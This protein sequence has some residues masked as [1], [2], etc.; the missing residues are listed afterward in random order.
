MIRIAYETQRLSLRFFLLMLVLF[1]VQTF[2]GLLIAA[3]HIDPT[4]LSGTL[5]FNVARTEHTNLGIFW[6]LSGFIATI[7]FVGP[8]LSKRELAAPWLIKFLFYALLA[9][10]IWNIITQSLAQKGIAGWWMGQPMLQEGL[11]YLEAGRIADIVILIGFSILCYIVL[12]TFPP[13]SSWNEIHWGLGLGVLA[14][15]AVWIFGM[16]FVERLDLQEY[17]RWY[18]VHYWVEGVWEVI[19]ISLVGFLLILMFKADVKAVG[20]AVFWGISLVWLSGLLGNAHHYFWIGT[21]EFWQFWGSLFSALEPLPLIFCFWHI[22]LDAHQ[23]E[24]P[25]ANL[26][27]FAFLLGS[28]VLEQV[29][30]GI[31]GFTMTFALTNVWSHGTW[32]T[33]SH[34]HL[35]LFGTFGML[36][37]SAAYYAVP[38]MRGVEHFDQRAGKLAFWLV[39]T[40]MLGLGFA[41]A[42]GGS[43]Q[44]FVYRTLGL[45]WFA[46]DVA[47][48]MQFAKILVPIFG[49]VFTVGVCLLVFDLLTLGYR[50]PVVSNKPVQTAAAMA[51]AVPT[52]WSRWLTGWEAG[53]WLLGMW[54][55]GGIITLGL[56]SFNLETVRQGNA[57]LPYLMASIGYPGLLLVTLF[58]VWRFLNS[59]EARER[60]GAGRAFVAVPVTEGAA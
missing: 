53:L 10:V 5:N 55:F 11:E 47:P 50:R 41:F 33:A 25:V 39:F 29:G 8:L 43:V 28:V 37:L 34:A 3:Q 17:F 38:I 51:A 22:Y 4:L 45:D 31:L 46:G 35:A 13:M 32:V 19:H 12:R 26:P 40:G 60:I 48:A 14:L 18:V 49:I 6:I 42:I 2:F 59:L 24:K 7:L 57:M 54:V 15:T 52:R 56:L 1:L 16:F 27:A 58:F 36:G 21:P 20:Y 44:V 9:V 23:D 30:A